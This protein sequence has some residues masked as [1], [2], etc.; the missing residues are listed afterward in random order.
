MLTPRLHHHA[1]TL[2]GTCTAAALLCGCAA[3]SPTLVPAP[4]A[5]IVEIDGTGAQKTAAEVTV[6]AQAESWRGADIEDNVTPLRVTIQN[7]GDRPV[8]LRYSDFS[9][10]GTRGERYAALPPYE[11]EGTVSRPAMARDYRALDR[12]DF[13]YSRF[14]VAPHYR[15]VYP[16]LSAYQL[17]RLYFDPYYYS[18]YYPYWG[19]IEEDLPTPDMLRRVIPEGVIQSQGSVSGFLYFEHVDE[20]LAQARLDFHAELVDAETG[21]MFATIN[22]PFIANPEATAAG[23]NVGY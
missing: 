12:L 6:T 5:N 23:R 1:G 21:E 13:R 10:V 14:R 11:I 17:H 19:R 16:T 2:I 22:I 8:R 4:D 7:D 18:Y 15:F 3:E 20:D 9:L